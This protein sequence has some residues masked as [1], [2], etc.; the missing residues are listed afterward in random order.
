MDSSR[1]YGTGQSV[2]AMTV[3]YLAAQHPE[4]FAAELIVSGQ[5][6]L[7]ALEALTGENFLYFAV[8]GDVKVSGGQPTSRPCSTR[9][10][11][12]TDRRRWMQRRQAHNK[13]RRLKRCS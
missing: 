12:A 5:W 6:D 4:L 9:Q 13:T 2:R 10:G 7:T 11:S 8:S 3:M 1:I